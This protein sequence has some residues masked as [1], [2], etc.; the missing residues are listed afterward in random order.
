MSDL[1]QIA[2]ST[3]ENRKQLK[4]FLNEQRANL[5]PVVRNGF[6]KGKFDFENRCLIGDNGYRL[7]WKLRLRP[8]QPI[9]Y[10]NQQTSR[11]IVVVISP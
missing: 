9:D 1:E 2:L 10:K 11:G 7:Q 8:E 4:A 6:G 3:A 5:A